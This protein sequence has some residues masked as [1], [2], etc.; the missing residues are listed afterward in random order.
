MTTSAEKSYFWAI[1]LDADHKEQKW[2]GLTTENTDDMIMVNHTLAVRQAVVGPGCKEDE[3]QVVEMEATGYGNKKIKVPVF[4]SKGVTTVPTELL[5]T[6]QV[7]TFR[8]THGSGP[9]YI[10]G[11]HATESSVHPDDDED[12]DGMME[13]E[14]DDIE[15]EEEDLGPTKKK[16]K[17]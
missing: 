12:E 15:E 16:A 11:T 6:D 14:E 9:V 17:K 13:P 10:S 7:V 8:L 3:V 4:A 1:T 2:D 5:L